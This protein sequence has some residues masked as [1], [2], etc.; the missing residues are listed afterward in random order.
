MNRRDFLKRMGV[1][2][3]AVPLAACSAKNNGSDD[4]AQQQNKSN[5]QVLKIIQ[6]KHFIAGYDEWFD[7]EFVVEWGKKNGVT[8]EVTHLSFGDLFPLATGL[9]ALQSGCDIF[10]FTSPPMAFEEDVVDMRDVGEALEERFGPMSPQ[11]KN[12]LYNPETGKWTGISDH[13]VPLIVNWRQDL[14]DQ[15][16]PGSSPDT[17]DDV[18]RVGRKLKL[19]GNPIGLGMSTDL[20]SNIALLG[21]LNAYGASIQDA[22]GRV[23]VNSPQTVEALKFGAA[24]YAEAMQPEILAWNASSNNQFMLAGKGSFAMNAISIT[25]VAEKNDPQLAQKIALSAPPAGPVQRITPANVVNIYTVWKFSQQIDIAK[26]FIQDLILAS[27]TAF[28]KSELYNYPSFPGAV[29]NLSQVYAGEQK[30]QFLSSSPEWVCNIGYPGNATAVANEVVDT[31]LVPKAFSL[32]AIGTLSPEE[33]AR[34]LETE[35]NKI[36][37]QWAVRNAAKY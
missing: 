28:E 15:V 13:W 22:G 6:Q 35:V 17:W 33:G 1:L 8:V 20:D 34:W 30:Y 21:L 31:Y 24:L 25:R 2:A 11:A 9:V 4:P 5:G 3:G 19:I 12:S 14:W 23:T 32:V 36:V 27:A 29:P 16:E 10:G 18:L 37:N 26:Q 7:Q